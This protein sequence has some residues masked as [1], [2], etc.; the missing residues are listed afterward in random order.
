MNTIEVNEHLYTIKL[1]LTG[2]T[3]YG[4][5]FDE[6]TSGTIP[7]PPE[8]ARFDAAFEGRASGPRL[9]GTV[10]GVDYLRVRGDGRMELHIHETISTADGLNI[11]AQGD[12]VGIPRPEGGIIDIRVNMTL[13]TSSEEY[14]WVNLLPVWGVGIVNLVEGTVEVTCYS[15]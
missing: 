2:M 10:A 6:L 12:G 14:K 15:A 13:F 4:V 11:D 7:P 1:N 3:E 9:N 5:D 8:G